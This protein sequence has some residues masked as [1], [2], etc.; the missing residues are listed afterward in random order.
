MHCIG[1]FSACFPFVFA[2]CE[3]CVFDSLELSAC[4]RHD[5]ILHKYVGNGHSHQEW[6]MGHITPAFRA[7]DLFYKMRY[8]TTNSFSSKS[9][10][11]LNPMQAFFKGN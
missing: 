6:G 2:N 9:I 5:N 11:S 1:I 7:Q 4:S 10:F 3:E 8:C